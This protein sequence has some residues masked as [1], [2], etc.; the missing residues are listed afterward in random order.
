MELR[1]TLCASLREQS[2]PERME[3]GLLTN[4]STI[5][6][7]YMQDPVYSVVGLQDVDI[8][9]SGYRRQYSSARSDYPA[10]A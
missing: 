2:D 9:D 7:G 3:T 5:M 4:G 1:G 10:L 6:S 8:A